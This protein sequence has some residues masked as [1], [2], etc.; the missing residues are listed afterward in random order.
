MFWAQGVGFGAFASWIQGPDF[1]FRF[2]LQADFL[3]FYFWFQGLGFRVR[4]ICLGSCSVRMVFE[5]LEISQDQRLS[6]G[7]GCFTASIG[8]FWRIN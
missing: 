3:F 4:G 5:K 8:G 7:A 1:G 6:L 2:L